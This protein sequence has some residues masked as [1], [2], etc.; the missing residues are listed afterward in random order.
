MHGFR[1]EA[2][3]HCFPKEFVTFFLPSEV[4]VLL[5]KRIHF[6]C[7]VSYK[8]KTVPATLENLSNYLW[9]EGV[10]LIIRALSS[11]SSW[12]YGFQNRKTSFRV[13]LGRT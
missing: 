2:S 5:A 7:F 3:Q 1:D 6:G 8:F 10:T 4:R 12:V 9:K 13:L 11:C